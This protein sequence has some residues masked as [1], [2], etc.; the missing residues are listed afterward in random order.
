MAE[1]GVIK[2]EEVKD[3]TILMPVGITTMEHEKGITA[4][5]FVGQDE[6]EK[7]YVMNFLVKSFYRETI[8]KYLK[9]LVPVRMSK[10]EEK[11]DG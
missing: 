4:Y 1:E 10:P 5:Q 9:K 8:D 7:K 11:I 3:I 6:K 2:E